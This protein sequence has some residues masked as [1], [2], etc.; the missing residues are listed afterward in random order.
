VSKRYGRIVAVD[1]LGFTLPSG[2]VTGVLGPNGSGKSTTMRMQQLGAGQVGRIIAS[3]DV[4]PSRHGGSV[5]R[6]ESDH[7]VKEVH[8]WGPL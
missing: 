4:G 2:E 3:R 7:F 5:H 1:D 6:V 8:Q